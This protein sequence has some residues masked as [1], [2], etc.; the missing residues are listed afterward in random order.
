MAA[1]ILTIKEA[2]TAVKRDSDYDNE[3]SELLFSYD[4]KIAEGTGLKWQ[5]L[6]PV[7]PSAKLV[8]RLM[9]QRYVGIIPDNDLTERR[10]TS[11]M[12]TLQGK[13]LRMASEGDGNGRRF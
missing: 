2:L 13:V 5:D 7:D 6:D 11:I 8:Q 4:D 1:N 3:I 9:L 10:I 12:K